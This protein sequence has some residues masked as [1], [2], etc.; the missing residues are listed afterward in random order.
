[1]RV[2]QGSEEGGIR[3]WPLTS[4]ELFAIGLHSYHS[5]G[6]DFLPRRARIIRHVAIC[7]FGGKFYLQSTIQS[8]C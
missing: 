4:I 1:M 7:F 5:L 8:F 3:H 2:S 6:L